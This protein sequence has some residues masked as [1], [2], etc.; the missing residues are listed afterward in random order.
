MHIKDW[1][2]NVFTIPNILSLLRLALI[3]LYM[4]IYLNATTDAHYYISSGILAVSC[5]TDLIDGQIARR[6][7]MISTLGKILDPIAD[8]ATQFT[9]IFC[10]A[11][12]R[13]LPLLW[14]MITIFIAKE[15]FQLIAGGMILMKGKILSGAIL[16]GKVCTAILFISLVV[17]VIF[18]HMSDNWVNLLVIIDGLFL[19]ISFVAYILV[20]AG[21]INMIQNIDS[22][23]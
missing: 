6:C 2:K 13:N 23:C 5:L 11:V 9:L 4:Y 21:K 17:M 14:V 20:Y 3:P 7:N 18:P 16:H 12:R 1:K 22:G 15:G 19:I 8:K 10:L